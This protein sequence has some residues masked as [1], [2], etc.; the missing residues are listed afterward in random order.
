VPLYW[1]GMGWNPD[2]GRVAEA[3]VALEGL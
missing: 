2:N 1:Q 3:D